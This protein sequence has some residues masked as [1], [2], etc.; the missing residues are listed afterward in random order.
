V[1]SYFGAV[2]LAVIHQGNGMV[3][4]FHAIY[5]HSHPGIR[6]GRLQDGDVIHGLTMA[7]GVDHKMRFTAVRRCRNRSLDTLP[8]QTAADSSPCSQKSSSPI[9]C[10]RN[11]TSHRDHLLGRIPAMLREF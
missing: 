7:V 10:S 6:G 8:L 11:S 9:S 5:S 1:D 2:F 4:S 3:I